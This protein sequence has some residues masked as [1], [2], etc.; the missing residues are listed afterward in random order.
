MPIPIQSRLFLPFA[1]DQQSL[2]VR[3]LASAYSPRDSLNIRVNNPGRIV[4]FGGYKQ[5][6]AATGASGGW[7]YLLPYRPGSGTSVF[8]IGWYGGTYQ[9]VDRGLFYDTCDFLDNTT[10]VTWTPVTGSATYGDFPDV[11]QLGNIVIACRVGLVPLQITGSPPVASSAA[12]TRLAAPTHGSAVA[13]NVRGTP[14]WKVLPKIGD[15]PKVASAASLPAV[16]DGASILVTWVAD[17]DTNVTGYDVYRTTGTGGAFFYVDT[18]IGRTTVTYRD[19]VADAT[20]VNNRALIEHGDAPP[21]TWF[22]EVHKQRMWFL[23]DAS[24]AGQRSI[25]YSDPGD[26]RSVYLDESKFDL[27]DERTYGDGIVGGIGE[28][29]GMLIVL[30]TKSIYTIS[31]SGQIIGLT[32]DFTPRR[33]DARVGS[34]GH[35]TAVV[36]PAGARYTDASGAQQETTGPTLAYLSSVKDIR[37]FDG[38]GD[39]IISWPKADVL[40]TIGISQANGTIGVPGSNFYFHAFHDTVRSLVI[41]YVGINGAASPDTAIIWNYLHATWHQCDAQDVAAVV[42][43]A[44]IGTSDINVLVGVG[45][46]TTSTMSDRAVR[47]YEEVTRFGSAMT[48][49]LRLAPLYFAAAG[50]EEPDFSSVKRYLELELLFETTASPASMA[51]RCFQPV[52]GLKEALPSEDLLLSCN[53]S[54]RQYLQLKTSGGGTVAADGLYM[55]SRGLT[56]TVSEGNATVP[57]TLEAMLVR[58]QVLP[59]IR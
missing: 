56:V 22:C 7:R 54:N 44:E 18:V 21:S 28:F 51:V 49:M 2:G 27:T 42:N 39:T 46:S 15:T 13:G 32:V 16:I 33:T 29:R 58:Y 47:L 34:C 45:F 20:I 14:R 5:I 38:N 40:A 3:A 24:A 53:A 55:Q 17:A 30:L 48:S 41:W 8:L 31:G 12:Y 25:W 10:D 37:L 43:A 59:G 50:A 35:R 52:V 23:N 26:P 19:N 36:V 9:T 1:G 4:K 6:G 11:A 57:W